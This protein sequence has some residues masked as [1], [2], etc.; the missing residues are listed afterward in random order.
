[1]AAESF[2]I[3]FTFVEVTA[4]DLERPKKQLWVALAKPSQALTLV[5]TAVPEGWTA[6]VVNDRLTPGQFKALGDLGLKPGEVRK[7]R[8]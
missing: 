2:G 4:D 8:T 5:L 3:E 7:L 6:Q 1:M